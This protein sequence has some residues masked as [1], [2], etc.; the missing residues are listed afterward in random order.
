[1]TTNKRTANIKF[2]I[3]SQRFDGRV[4]EKIIN[5]P[6]TKNI[7]GRSSGDLRLSRDPI[8]IDTDT[9][10]LKRAD[11]T[12]ALFGTSGQPNHESG[13]AQAVVG[14]QSI[15][16]SAVTYE[17]LNDTPAW[18]NSTAYQPNDY[19]LH[20]ATIYKATQANT[21]QNPSSNSAA[22]EEWSVQSDAYDVQ[23]TRN[24]LKVE[25]ASTG[26]YTLFENSSWTSDTE[27]F[28]I[29]ATISAS[30]AYNQ[31]II[32]TKR[33][34]TLEN[35]KRY[36]IL[37]YETGDDFSNSGVLY[38]SGN[39][40]TNANGEEFTANSTAPTWTQGSQLYQDISLI[41]VPVSYTHLTLPTIYSV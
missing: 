41:K 7:K 10:G 37:D 23:A 34:G 27:R 11:G 9:Q 40:I 5:Q 12:T 29:R 38:P 33:S 30:E 18:D 35:G 3:T 8:N 14:G 28:T 24:G 19:V 39:A 22:G 20:S 21:G 32:E 4:I 36:V 16:D 17:I 15:P 1:M 2:T 26:V 31:G 6:F 13:E 25:I